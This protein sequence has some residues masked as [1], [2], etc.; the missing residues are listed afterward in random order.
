MSDLSVG[1][2]MVFVAG[3]SCVVILE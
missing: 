2:I 1:L 3:V